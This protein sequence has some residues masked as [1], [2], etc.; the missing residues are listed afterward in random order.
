M[1]THG[2]EQSDASSSLIPSFQSHQ[3]PSSWGFSPQDS[4]AYLLIGHIHKAK[5]L[6]H[7][8][9]LLLCGWRHLLSGILRIC[10]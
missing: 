7:Q 3:H 8:Q 6:L 2:E 5:P 10:I 9:H 1:N 4:S